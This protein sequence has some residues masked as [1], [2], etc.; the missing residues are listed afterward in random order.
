[1]EKGRFL[2][3]IHNC[4]SAQLIRLFILTY[5]LFFY[6][7]NKYFAIAARTVERSLKPDIRKEADRRYETELKVQ[8]LNDGE[9]TKIVDLNTGKEIAA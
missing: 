2:V 6:S 3:S 5:S 9:V 1:M 8:T 7:I 4:S